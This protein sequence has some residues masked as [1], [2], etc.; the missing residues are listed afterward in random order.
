MGILLSVCGL[1]QSKV[2]FCWKKMSIS[3]MSFIGKSS[4]KE[5]EPTICEKATGY[6]AVYRLMFGTFLF[7]IF[8]GFIMIKI[9]SKRDPRIALHRGFWLIKFIMLVSIIFGSFYIPDTGSFGS[10]PPDPDPSANDEENLPSS[11]S[12]ESRYDFDNEKTKSPFDYLDEVLEG[13]PD[14][15]H[16]REALDSSET[17]SLINEYGDNM[18]IFAPNDS[19][20]PESPQN[21][22]DDEKK[23]FLTNHA[24]L[25]QRMPIYEPNYDR[26]NNEENG[27]L[28]PNLYKSSSPIVHKI[29]FFQKE[30]IKPGFILKIQPLLSSMRQ[31]IDLSGFERNFDELLRD[32][33]FSGPTSCQKGM[34]NLNGKSIDCEED[35]E[36]IKI[37]DKIMPKRMISV[38]VTQMFLIDN[39]LFDDVVYQPLIIPV[40]FQINYEVDPDYNLS[41]LGGR[42][43]REPKDESE[44]GENP[45][46]QQPPTRNHNKPKKPHSEKPPQQ[47]EDEE[48]D[49]DENPYPQ[50]P[51]QS[52]PKK[53]KRPSN[54]KPPQ[55]PENEEEPEK[56]ESP[57][58]QQQPKSN[59]KKPKK[60]PQQ[61]ENEEEPEKDES[62]YPQQP[63]QSNPK[64]PKR[65]SNQ[66]PPQQ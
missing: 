56:D 16:S 50:Q 34:T 54:Q 9:Q 42:Y 46:P 40:K 22:N 53:S 35:E 39:L 15:N 51:P 14:L 24:L 58:P 20:F 11:K 37:N 19:A 26:E 62:P 28:K 66:K 17:E 64:K 18:T 4:E 3:V 32:H 38:G 5:P 41:D 55:Q 48:P 44:N 7:F 61:P 52:N 59:P 13:E 36:T 23:E 33:S 12:V 30:P 49:N 29:N 65:P 8:F 60:P 1:S 63:P 27:V 57:Y 45:F 25:G 21:W 31:L 2:P 10:T 6:L 43:H 47:P